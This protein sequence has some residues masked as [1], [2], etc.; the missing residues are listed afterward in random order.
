MNKKWIVIS[1]AAAVAVAFIAGIMVFRDRSTAL[2]TQAVQNN[3][4]ALVRA[5]SPVYG[6]PDAK[7]TI[8]EF[9]DPACETCRIFYPIVKRMVNSSFGQVRLVVRY[10]PLHKGSDTAIKILEAARKQDKYWEVV[11]KTF[12]HQPQWAAHGNPQPELIWDVIKDTGL[13]VAKARADAASPEIDQLLRQDLADMMALK[14]DKTPGFFVNG[15][16]LED[17][18]N[19]QLK[20]LVQEEVRL[21]YPSKN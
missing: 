15:R 18:G 10:A 17:F 1:T 9:F 16:P 6:N 2:V 7:V 3:N 21:A 11:E 12:A 8:V 19:E 20:A 4:E 13:D 14:V 5:H